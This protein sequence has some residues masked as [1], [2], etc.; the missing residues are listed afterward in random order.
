MVEAQKRKRIVLQPRDICF[1]SERSGLKISSKVDKMVKLLFRRLS[2]SFAW[3]EAIPS[4]QQVTIQTE[5]WQQRPARSIHKPTHLF[6]TCC[7]MFIFLNTG[8]GD[9][10]KLL[11]PSVIQINQSRS[12]FQQYDIASRWVSIENITDLWSKRTWTLRVTKS[13]PL[14]WPSQRQHPTGITEGDIW[15]TSVYWVANYD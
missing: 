5:F 9:F 3:G 7:E 13:K 2:N 14:P 1:I 8:R 4:S 12:W 11:E 10:Q 15:E 6:Y